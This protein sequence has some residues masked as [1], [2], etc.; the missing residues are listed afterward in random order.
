[1]HSKHKILQGK[2]VFACL[3]TECHCCSA[4]K[5]IL[6]LKR[7]VLKAQPNHN[8]FIESACLRK[9]Y[10]QYEC[11]DSDSYGLL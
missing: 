11:T 3:A 7:A 5:F 9:C 6:H 4:V 8:G 1:M 10:R 2:A